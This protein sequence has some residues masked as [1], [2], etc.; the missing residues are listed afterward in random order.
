VIGRVVIAGLGHLPLLSPES[1]AVRIRR[2]AGIAAYVGANG[3]FK[4][5]TAAMDTAPTLRG[6]PWHCENPDHLHTAEGR[7][8]GLRTVLSTMRFTMPDGTDHPL[9]RPLDDYT[10]IMG[11]EHCDLVLDEVGGA[12]GSTSGGDDVPLPVKASLQEL[13][14]RD[15]L[16]RHTAPSWA[17]A[18]KVLRECTQTVNL[19]MGFVPSRAGF[20]VEFDGPHDLQRLDGDQVLDDVCD[21]AKP[22]KHDAGR[23]WSSRR[24]GFVR[25]YDATVFEEWTAGKREKHRPLARQVFW[26]PGHHAG[27]LYDTHGYVL[28]L[29]QVT[30]GGTCMDCGG[31]RAKKACSCPDYAPRRQA[32]SDNRG[33]SDGP[34]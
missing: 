11:A 13:R 29:G 33:L 28:K 18:T 23:Q 6:I 8:S 4:S 17:R 7:T 27:D 24:L 3:H 31:R 32:R 1:K 12:A 2:G 15:V 26:R 25:T 30:D 34:L 19:C 14:R 22:H 16:C 5:Y 9:W 10:K 20:N 21:I